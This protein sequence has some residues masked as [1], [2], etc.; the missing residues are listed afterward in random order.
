MRDIIS[1]HSILDF[2]QSVSEISSYLE[3]PISADSFKEVI[4][5]PSMDKDTMKDIIMKEIRSCNLEVRVS[6]SKIPFQI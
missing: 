4:M 5:G 6:E 3:I 2:Q 1:A